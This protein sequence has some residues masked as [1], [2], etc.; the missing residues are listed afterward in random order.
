MDMAASAESHRTCY[1]PDFPCAWLGLMRDE[2]WLIAEV[3]LLAVHISS[4]FRLLS[5]REQECRD[6]HGLS[7]VRPFKAVHVS[8][9]SVSSGDRHTVGSLVPCP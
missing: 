9:A 8:G 6:E 1:E 5:F 3:P 2:G 7:R 4:L